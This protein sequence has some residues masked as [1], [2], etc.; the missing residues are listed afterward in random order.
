[1]APVTGL[2]NPLTI[3]PFIGS[4]GYDAGTVRIATRRPAA[5]SLVHRAGARRWLPFTKRTC[6]VP[7]TRSTKSRMPCRPGLTPVT[8][9]VQAGNV[10]AGMVDRS[11]PHAPAS[12]RRESTGSSPAAAQ[13]A[14]RSSVAPSSPI[15]SSRALTARASLQVAEGPQAVLR[16]AVD[17]RL[18]PGAAMGPRFEIG[19]SE[20][21]AQLLEQRRV[22]G[23]QAVLLPG[24]GL[25][26]V[27]LLGLQTARVAGIRGDQLRRRRA[28]RL[29]HVALEVLLREHAVAGRR[30]AAVERQRMALHDRG[31]RQPRGRD[32]RGRDVEAGRELV[33]HAAARSAGRRL[34]DERHVN[35]LV[36]ER[37][38]VPPA[39]VLVELLAVVAG[40]HD[41]HLVVQTSTL[42]VGEQAAEVL[43]EIRDPAVVELAILLGDARLRIGIRDT[44]V[45]LPIE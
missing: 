41:E 9:D 13:G 10:A 4:G 7:G 32:D 3:T 33:D 27:K 42:E 34:Q 40:Q 36:V 39:T 16:D 19:S 5:D 2:S 8:R 26:V 29:E 14:T 22:G 28:H 38:A 15:T 37:G 18:R 12:I 23:D 35:L 1:M 25:Q 45:P 6:R 20:R 43:V 17:V 44:L 24:V 31:H 11:G 21:R 30:R